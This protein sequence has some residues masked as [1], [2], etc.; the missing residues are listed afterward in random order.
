M[1][2]R[3]TSI[4]TLFTALP[5]LKAG[6]PASAI[7]CNMKVLEN[8]KRQVRTA[9]GLSEPYCAEEGEK[10]YGHGQGKGDAGAAW[11]I[12]SE[13]VFRTLDKLTHC[14]IVN[15]VDKKITVEQSATGFIDDMVAA[16]EC[17][18]LV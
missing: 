14:Q 15:S 18:T 10:L 13:E 9:Q 2:V 11:C 1:T 17:E 16:C 7:D 8:A 4:P 3:W 5:L 6:M 12:L